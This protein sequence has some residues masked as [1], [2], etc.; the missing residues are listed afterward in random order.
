MK[1]GRGLPLGPMFVVSVGVGL[2]AAAIVFAEADTQRGAQIAAA[3]VGVPILLLGIVCWVAAIATW[4]SVRG[5]WWEGLDRDTAE[6]L[7]VAQLLATVGSDHLH[8]V[9]P[10]MRAANSL[11]D[12]NARL[13]ARMD[14]IAYKA[15]R[16]GASTKDERL[17]AMWKSLLEGRD[18]LQQLCREIRATAGQTLA[19]RPVGRITPDE[20]LLSDLS[21]FADR[22]KALDAARRELESDL[23][24]PGAPVPTSPEHPHILSLLSERAADLVEPATRLQEASV[25]QKQAAMASIQRWRAEIDQLPTETPARERDRFVAERRQ[26]VQ[27]T[28]QYIK[29]LE[30][31][32]NAIRQVVIHLAPPPPPPAPPPM[33][34]ERGSVEAADGMINALREMRRR[35]GEGREL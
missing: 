23:D 24:R 6:V 34:Y 35:T 4:R 22:V 28:E 29:R 19:E 10:S 15:S 16:R 21:A 17:D 31:E 12:D 3:F 26:A 18:R 33:E 1:S 25:R 20:Q 32:E 5:P 9:T 8:W 14:R 27:H 30:H 7:A 11:R 13:C 2:I